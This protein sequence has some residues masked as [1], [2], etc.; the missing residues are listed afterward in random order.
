M[1]KYYAMSLKRLSASVLC[2]KMEN[3]LSQ[4]LNQKT[5]LSGF[6]K[7]RALSWHHCLL[8]LPNEDMYKKLKTDKNTFR[9]FQV[10]YTKYSGR[11]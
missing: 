7:I 2:E 9:N 11:Q 3:T 10:L 8:F 6:C 4:K 1:L 5:H